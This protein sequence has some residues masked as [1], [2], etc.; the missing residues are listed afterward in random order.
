MNTSRDW[1]GQVLDLYNI[2][3]A[4]EY[5]NNLGFELYSSES[6]K[7]ITDMINNMSSTR[8]T[9]NTDNLYD[10]ILYAAITNA[11]SVLSR[12]SGVGATHDL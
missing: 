2:S 7:P 10:T 9:R 1:Q 6:N 8:I 4:L 12:H 5:Y 11:I 3:G